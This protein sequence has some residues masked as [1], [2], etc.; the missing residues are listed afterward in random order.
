MIVIIMIELSLIF[1]NAYNC[2]NNNRT[3]PSSLVELQ[4]QLLTHLILHPH[5]DCI[6]NIHFHI[7]LRYIPMYFYKYA[8]VIT[9]E[10]VNKY[11]N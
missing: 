10:Y 8:R 1:I 3:C 5:I 4:W 11:C 6:T 7:I 2:N 9:K